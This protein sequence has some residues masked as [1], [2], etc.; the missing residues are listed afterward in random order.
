[1]ILTKMIKTRKVWEIYK[2]SETPKVQIWKEQE[3][4]GPSQSL[5][6]LLPERLKF[7]C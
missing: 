2:H 5:D 7:A 4:Q 6:V 1:M 3:T